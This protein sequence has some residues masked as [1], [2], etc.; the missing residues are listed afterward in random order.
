MGCKWNGLFYKIDEGGGVFSPHP[1][2]VRMVIDLT[3]R[4]LGI[5]MVE[6]LQEVLIFVMQMLQIGLSL[7]SNVIRMQR[8]LHLAFDLGTQSV[9]VSDSLFRCT[10]YGFLTCI[11]ASRA[12]ILVQPGNLQGSSKQNHP[13][14][15]GVRFKSEVTELRMIVL[16]IIFYLGV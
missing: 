13:R 10:S 14:V 6:S 12:E 1:V 4:K 7:P 11:F 2:V 15:T 9:C 5:W 3:I 8:T 16:P